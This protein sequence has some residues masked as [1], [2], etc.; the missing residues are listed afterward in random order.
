VRETFGKHFEEN[1]EEMAVK[2][3][4]QFGQVEG[5]PNQDGVAFFSNLKNAPKIILVGLDIS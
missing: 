5:I 1:D 2:W 3:R 4:R